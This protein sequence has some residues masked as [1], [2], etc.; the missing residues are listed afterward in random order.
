VR[1]TCVPP[2][3][4]LARVPPYSGQRN[5]ATL[6]DDV[7]AHFRRAIDVR[8]AGTKI[9]AFDGIVKGGKPIA[10]VLIVFAALIPPC[11]AMEY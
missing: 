5:L 9:A 4:R 10:V 8:F 6:V 1:E 3:E 7:K 11:A 2:N